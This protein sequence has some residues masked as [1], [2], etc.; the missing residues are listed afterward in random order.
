[1]RVIFDT[2]I[3]GLLATE[4]DGL[5]LQERIQSEKDFI[6]YGYA[7][8]RREL[9][10]ISTT[11]KLSRRNRLFLLHLYDAIT[12]S[13][14]LPNSTAVNHLAKKYYDYYLHLGGGYAWETSIRIDFLLVACASMHQLDVVYSNDAKTLMNK[15]ALK[16]YAHINRKENKPTPRFVKY[17]ELIEKFRKLV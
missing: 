2:N 1:M 9:R 13:R 11:S 14:L 12:G 6:V 7:P 16:T 8:I 5:E 17:E 4:P 3:Y 10:N 15:T